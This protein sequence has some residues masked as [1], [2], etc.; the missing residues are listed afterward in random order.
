VDCVFGLAKNA[1]PKKSKSLFELF[2][3]A[4]ESQNGFGL[5]PAAQFFGGIL[6][7]SLYRGEK[8]YPARRCE[9][10]ANA[11]SV[12]RTRLYQRNIQCGT[13]R[14]WRDIGLSFKSAIGSLE[15]TGHWLQ[16][17]Y[18]TPTNSVSES[19]PW[20]FEGYPSLIWRDYLL[21]RTRHAPS[22]QSAIQTA[23]N[24]VK[25]AKP[26]M[27][28]MLASPGA[29]DADAGVLAI[30]GHWLKKRRMLMDG[31]PSQENWLC[32]EGWI[33]GLKT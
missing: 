30:G 16:V 25:I 17:R 3:R 10:L 9:T 27:D 1:W 5:E 7:D 31:A 19:K 20:V 32:R 23:A 28:L 8:P 24:Y 12:F 15:P 6:A 33:T 29:A 11:N 22:L 2:N 14:I 4:A 21:L 18:F 13:Y 26:D